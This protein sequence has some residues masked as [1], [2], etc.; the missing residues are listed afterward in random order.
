MKLF[1]KKLA[2]FLLGLCVVL[3]SKPWYEIKNKSGYEVR[4]RRLRD[5]SPGPVLYPAVEQ[6]IL[7]D[8]TILR[9]AEFDRTPEIVARKDGEWVAI[10]CSRFPEKSDK[11]EVLIVTYN[12]KTQKIEVIQ[13]L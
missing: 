9:L 11:N 13:D 3:T 7:K 6:H 12:E 10:D 4:V 1:S 2:I 5:R 8:N